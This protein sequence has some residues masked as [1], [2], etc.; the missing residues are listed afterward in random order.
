ML[1]CTKC[2]SLLPAYA[3]GEANAHACPSCGTAF[4]IQLF[5]ALVTGPQ[6]LTP[7]DLTLAEGAASCFHHASKRAHASC[8]KCGKFLCALCSLEI[9]DQV[10]CSQCL[11]GGA[12][13]GASPLEERRVLWDSI[14][15][16]LA[17]GTTVVLF[18]FYFWIF[19]A[20][21]AIFIAL[22]YWNR[23]TSLLP[24]TKIRFV[25]AIMLGFVQIAAWL[26]IARFAFI[27]LRAGK[28]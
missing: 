6:R 17:V 12:G 4:E 9:G 10:W 16:G 18:L 15:L 7:N 23:P 19:T 20:P 13:K 5:P 28:G 14:A 21:A 2:W 25:L 27:G 24:R 1:S 26:V 8:M 22:K 11:S 3:V